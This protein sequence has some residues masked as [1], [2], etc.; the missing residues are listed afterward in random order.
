MAEPVIVPDDVPAGLAAQ[1]PLATDVGPVL[2]TKFGPEPWT[3]TGMASCL[4]Q[5]PTK[6]NGSSTTLEVAL[7][8]AAEYVLRLVGPDGLSLFDS[9]PNLQTVVGYAVT[10]FATNR[11]PGGFTF[12]T[13]LENGFL[14]FVA[15][16]ERPATPG[17]IPVLNY[18]FA[19][20]Q[21]VQIEFQQSSLIDVTIGSTT[22]Q[23]V[24]NFTATLPTFTAVA[25][26]DPLD[27]GQ[28]I[29]EP[30]YCNQQFETFPKL[31][32]FV[33]VNAGFM[34]EA[35]LIDP[36]ETTLTPL[37]LPRLDVI[38]VEL[39]VK[40]D[41]QFTVSFREDLLG[42][43]R[44]TSDLVFSCVNGLCATQSQKTSGGSGHY[45]VS[46]FRTL[47]ASEKTAKAT[48]FLTGLTDPNDRV[49]YSAKGKGTGESIPVPSRKN[50]FASETRVQKPANPFC[51]VQD[52]NDDKF[53]IGF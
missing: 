26:T 33:S 19:I 29:A 4:T 20:G 16:A 11:R 45:I 47:S 31:K 30:L 38:P 32:S 21:P 3:G 18:G 52:S 5:M 28:L 37:L 50:T 17:V 9:N 48:L 22:E 15:L 40:G 7:P 36:G 24:L 12:D 43:S 51:P 42:G 49:T 10:N 39:V 44:N 46:F 35:N 1:L 13:D 41:D 25:G 23:R 6:H 2:F 14:Q 53:F 27:L 8:P 34:A